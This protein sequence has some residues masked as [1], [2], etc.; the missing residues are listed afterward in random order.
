MQTR[1]GS[2][3]TTGPST[4]RGAAAGRPRPP[5]FIPLPSAHSHRTH[6]H[7]HTFPAHKNI[8]RAVQAGTGRCTGGTALMGSRRTGRQ[9]TRSATSALDP[10]GAGMRVS[11]SAHANAPTT[12]TPHPDPNSFILANYHSSMCVLLATRPFDYL[13]RALLRPLLCHGRPILRLTPLLPFPA[14]ATG[15]LIMCVLLAPRPFASRLLAPRP[16][17]SP[18][19]PRAPNPPPH[20]APPFSRHTGRRVRLL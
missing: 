6:K 5:P 11:T 20:P 13:R 16:F 19:M 17:A 9:T 4:V 2:H 14:T 3:Q 7:T 10:Y 15:L 8:S 18:F 1:A 12:Q